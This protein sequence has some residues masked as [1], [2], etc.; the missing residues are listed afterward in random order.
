M[1]AYRRI[2]EISLVSLI[3][4]RPSSTTLYTMYDNVKVV[5][6]YVCF[7]HFPT[8]MHSFQEGHHQRSN[9]DAVKDCFEGLFFYKSTVNIFNINILRK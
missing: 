1:S 7:H 2:D 3:Y 5:N 4:Y 9:I 8:L 6:Y